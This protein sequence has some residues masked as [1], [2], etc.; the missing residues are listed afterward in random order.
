MEIRC[1]IRGERFQG[2]IWSGETTRTE[3]WTVGALMD[4]LPKIGCE[5]LSHGPSPLSI[6]DVRSGRVVGATRG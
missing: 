4:K 1:E 3:L 6:R 2:R 5:L